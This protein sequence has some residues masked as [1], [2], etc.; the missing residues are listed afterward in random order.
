VL[1]TLP[2]LASDI[3]QQIEFGGAG[4][5]G[6][7]LALGMAGAGTIRDE[8]VAGLSASRLNA[9][10]LRKLIESAWRREIGD[11][12]SF[13][14]ICCKAT[15]VIGGTDEWIGFDAA[16]GEAVVVF[17]SDGAIKWINAGAALERLERLGAGLAYTALRIIDVGLSFGDRSF[18]PL[19]ALDMAQWLYWQ[20]EVDEKMV[21]EDPESFGEVPAR[22]EIVSGIPEWALGTDVQS[23]SARRLRALAKQHARSADGPLLKALAAL[24]QALAAMRSQDWATPLDDCQ[25]M[26]PLAVVRWSDDDQLTR[27][28]DDYAEYVQ[29]GE[30]GPYAGYVRFDTSA[31]GISAALTRLRHCGL[32][33]KRLDD[34]LFVLSQPEKAK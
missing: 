13:S 27:V 5:C 24:A 28:F 20:G 8:D 1:L 15:L 10:T 2:S 25:Y 17:E 21:R 29:Q 30:I 18:S 33:W 26:D 6:L 12:F 3:P 22:S 11:T 19:G 7:R 23:V 16:D 9:R 14:T 34:V 31:E 32:L 4:R